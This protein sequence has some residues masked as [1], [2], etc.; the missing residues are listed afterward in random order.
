MSRH[1]SEKKRKALME[2]A[3]DLFSTQG[4]HA[5]PTQQIS[6]RAGVSA[7]TLFRYFRTKEELIDSL[8]TSI[9]RALADAVDEAIR[10]E[11]PVED[12]IKNVKRQ[13][14]HW[15]FENPK[16]TLFFEQFA[17]SPNIT[18]K[19]QKEG[20]IRFS[21]LDELYQKAVSRGILKGINRE[22]FLANFWY[23]NFMLIHLHT[24]G[25][26]QSDVEETI[27]QSVASMWCGME[28]RQ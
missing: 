4:F 18:K 20:F 28:Q 15:M 16:K 11:T 22:V 19:A 21:A 26:L 1:L 6:D 7:G 27:E 17:S 25:K 2:A 10:P 24:F 13:V 9:H 3:V 23:P 14:L 12:Q 5:T 8:H